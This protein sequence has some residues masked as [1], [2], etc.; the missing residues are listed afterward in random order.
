MGINWCSADFD[1]CLESPAMPWDEHSVFPCVSCLAESPFL[2]PRKRL[3]CIW[4]TRS[5]VVQ[6]VPS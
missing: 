3:G 6:M 4:E 5:S 1:P 2:P